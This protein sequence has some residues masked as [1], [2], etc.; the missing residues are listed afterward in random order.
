MSD[1]STPPPELK[2]AGRKLWE[3]MWSQLA[4]EVHEIPALREACML[5]DE[6]AALRTALAEDGRVYVK[7]YAGQ[8]V[9]NP[10]Y[11]EIRQTI[12][13]QAKLLSSIRLED[14]PAGDRKLTRSEAGR[15]AARSRWA[16]HYG[17]A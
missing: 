7:G 13:L 4:F 15:V 3:Q 1:L 6:L 11:A 17:S 5:A 12:Q 2:E 8:I 16:T 9:A 14:V 10:L